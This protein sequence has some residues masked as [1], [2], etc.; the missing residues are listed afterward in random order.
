MNIQTAFKFE[1]LIMIC[2]HTHFYG[3][4]VNPMPMMWCIVMRPELYKVESILE[5]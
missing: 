2:Y 5:N 3:C 4:H 1:V